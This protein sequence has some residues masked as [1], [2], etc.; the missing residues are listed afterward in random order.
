M[1]RPTDTP[2]VRTPEAHGTRVQGRDIAGN[3]K[4]EA[5]VAPKTSGAPEKN[6]AV[7]S[8][9]TPRPTDKPIDGKSRDAG[10]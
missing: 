6:P 5:P 4:R 1:A 7:P 10:G 2:S 9:M 3:D 8:R